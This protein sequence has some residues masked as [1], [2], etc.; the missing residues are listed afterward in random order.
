M[1]SNNININFSKLLFVLQ[2]LLGQKYGYCPFPPKIPTN[3][4]ESLLA[5]IED[6]GD[7][8]LIGQWFKQDDNAVPPEYVLQPITSKF[9]AFVNPP[10]REARK[11]AC[12]GWWEVFEKLQSILKSAA[13]KALSKDA[14]QKY[15]VSGESP[16]CPPPPSY[17]YFYSCTR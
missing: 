15:C 6:A 1:P 4:Y 16:S 12:K 11:A 9:P 3:E 5:S 2:T 10:S 7:K 8:D 13:A 14:G 17:S